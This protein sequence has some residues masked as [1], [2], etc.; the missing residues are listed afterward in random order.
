MKVYVVITVSE[1]GTHEVYRDFTVDKVFYTEAAA[2][3]YREQCMKKIF[4]YGT[5]PRYNYYV[6][7]VETELCTSEK[8]VEHLH[9]RDWN[10]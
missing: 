2:N 9:C 7:V 4:K 5:C 1:R 6:E 3:E 10:A 8:E